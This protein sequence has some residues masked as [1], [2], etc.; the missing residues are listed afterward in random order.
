[1]ITDEM[2]EKAAKEYQDRMLMNYPA[3]PTNAFS[4]QTGANFMRTEIEKLKKANEVLVEALKKYS[5]EQHHGFTAR[6]AL[7]SYNKIMKE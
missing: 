6:E 3:F 4:F 7:E 1:M 2:I 5:I